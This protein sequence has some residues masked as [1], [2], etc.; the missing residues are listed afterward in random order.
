MHVRCDVR[1]ATSRRHEAPAPDGVDR[2]LIETLA[3]AAARDLDA[4]AHDRPPKR[5][6]AA[7]TRPSS[8]ARRDSAGYDGAGL[9]R[10]AASK[11]GGITSIGGG[12]TTTAA[13]IGASDRH[14]R[15]DRR[16][17][18]F[19]GRNGE[20]RRDRQRHR[21]TVRQRARAIGGSIC[22]GSLRRA[23]S[24][25]R[26]S[27]SGSASLGLR[28]RCDQRDFDSRR[29]LGDLSPTASRAKATTPRGA[30][31]LRASHR[32]PRNR[33]RESLFATDGVA[34]QGSRREPCAGARSPRRVGPALP[35]ESTSR[36]FVA[37]M[38]MHKKTLAGGV[39]GARRIGTGGLAWR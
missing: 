26:R 7:A 14:R 16:D 30:H 2:R 31:G 12:A 35:I 11:R 29:R 13:G 15:F 23:V 28:W 8:R 5:G 20:R 3:S 34:S 36:C 19:D 37:S 22:G 27:F 17:R 9:S 24:G 18:R 33:R 32:E 6:R 21:A 1:V 39:P 4:F 25:T 38:R 10:Y